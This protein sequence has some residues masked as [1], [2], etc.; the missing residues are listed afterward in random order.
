M[1][2]IANHEG[3]TPPAARERGQNPTGPLPTEVKDRAA[4][5]QM[6]AA[7]G[8]PSPLPKEPDPLPPAARAAAPAAEPESLEQVEQTGEDNLIPGETQ[9]EAEAPTGEDEP[10]ETGEPTTAEPDAALTAAIG[11]LDETQRTQLADI[12]GAVAAGEASWNDIKQGHKLSVKHAAEVAELQGKIAELQAGGGT[13]VAPGAMNLP[14]TVAALKTVAECQ[15]RMDMAT[16]NA[17]TIQDFLDANPGEA[18]TVYDVTTG[19]VATVAADGQQYQTRKQLIDRKA[20]WRA[21]M[22]ALPQQAQSLQQ[23]ALFTQNQQ[24]SRA[25]FAESYPWINDPASAQ[26]KAVA[27]RLKAA[28]FLKSFVSPEYAAHVWNLGEK[29][30]EAERLAR[31]GKPAVAGAKPVGKVP[32]AKPHTNGGGPA[33]ARK[34]GLV[35]APAGKALLAAVGAKKDRGSLTALIGAAGF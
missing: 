31:G 11:G 27:E 23:Q 29:A 12:L 28:P 24:A 20:L 17:E 16:T 35:A 10:T 22:K 5:T 19:E 26:S 3:G 2:D 21:E 25:K 13:A 8:E 30:A 9:P 18:G 4:F 6:I 7:S 15:A 14:P 32:A 33:P 1:A 34:P